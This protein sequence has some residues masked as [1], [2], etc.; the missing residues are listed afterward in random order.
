MSKFVLILQFL[1]TWFFFLRR[2]VEES[3]LGD[4]LLCNQFEKREKD[5]QG[6]C[7]EDNY[8]KGRKKT[9]LEKGG[10]EKESWRKKKW[11]NEEGSSRQTNRISISCFLFGIGKET[12]FGTYFV[13]PV[14]YGPLFNK[15]NLFRNQVERGFFFFKSGASPLATAEKS[16]GG[17]VP[18]PILGE[19]T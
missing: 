14:R 12:C 15:R 7:G 6:I 17:Y 3:I 18:D 13:C 1:F 4:F 9:F 2:I 10:M 19:G 5:R 16:S 11:R 8:G